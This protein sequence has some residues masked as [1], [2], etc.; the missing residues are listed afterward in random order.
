MACS[1]S[2]HGI[3]ANLTLNNH[4]YSIHRIYWINLI[5]EW[6]FRRLH[7][8]LN[9]FNCHSMLQEGQNAKN[10]FTIYHFWSIK[11]THLIG[12]HK[13]I[14]VYLS[15]TFNY[16]RLKIRNYQVI[17]TLISIN[18]S[19]LSTHIPRFHL[20]N[21]APLFWDKCLYFKAI[22]KQIYTGRI[23]LI[24]WMIDWL[25]DYYILQQLSPTFHLLKL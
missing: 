6:P 22:L 13:N 1:R 18:I 23:K 3:F 10:K 5:L 20:A 17:Y 24:V 25:I 8:G 15:N 2:L 12:K 19:L 7:A 14:I 9:W 4:Q 21:W 11:I 16:L